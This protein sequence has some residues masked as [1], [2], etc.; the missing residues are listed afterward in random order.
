MNSERIDSNLPRGTSEECSGS[1]SVICIELNRTSNADT[2]TQ[3]NKNLK[4]VEDRNDSIDPA[5]TALV[6]YLAR[7]AAERDYESAQIQSKSA[8]NAHSGKKADS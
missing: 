4:K 8:A 6:K 2:M 1:A 3:Q 5:L 7:R